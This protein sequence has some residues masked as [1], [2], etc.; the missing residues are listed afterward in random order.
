MDK[1]RVKLLEV[2]AE[3]TNRKGYLRHI[4]YYTVKTKLN[5]GSPDKV[6][7]LEKP[8][9]LKIISRIKPE[10]RKFEA[11]LSFPTSK[12]HASLIKPSSKTF[13][14]GQGSEY[15]HAVIKDVPQF[16]ENCLNPLQKRSV[17][18]MAR[19][20]LSEP[21]TPKVCLMQGPPGTG[22]S[23]TI[24]GLVLQILYSGMEGGKRNSMPRILVVAPSNA[25]VDELALKLL[26][27]RRS[28]PEN[29]KFR[30]I[31]LGI[32]KSM[33]KEVAGYSFGANVD[34]IMTKGTRR[35]KAADTL[36]QDQKAKQVAANKLFEEKID[37]E[38]A[39]NSDLASK[40]H[41]DWRDKMQQIEK[42]KEELKKP[43]DSKAERN[44]RKN[45]EDTTMADADVILSTL[46]SSLNR[47][48][49]AYFVKGVGTSRT[50]GSIRPISVCIMDEASQCVEPEALIP[51]KLGFVKL[52]MV[53][54]HEQLPATVTSMR[55][56]KFGYQ[57]SLFG[58]LF[59]FLTGG[60]GSSQL[61]KTSSAG[62][63]PPMVLGRC[64]VV[65]LETQYR[66]H[67]EIAE[68]P[69]RYFYGGLV[70]SGD[71]NRTSVVAP[72]TVIHVQGEATMEGGNCYNRMEVG[73]VM[74]VIEV[75]REMLGQKPSVGVI[76]F[77]AKQK[78]L[79]S[80]EMQ[81]KK[82]DNIVVNTVDGFQGSERDVIIIS[83]V[84]G[85]AGGIGFLQDRQRL[86][87][88]L[89]RAK[90]NLVVIGNLATLE[91]SNKMW[92]ELLK[93]AKER[94]VYYDMKKEEGRLKEILSAVNM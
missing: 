52:V 4:V 83:C 89:T 60:G 29:I 55:A 2:T 30:L 51:F 85:G 7:A 48:M 66:M 79:L 69:C 49:D 39:G 58:R 18:S 72:F 38:N 47:E 11:L 20:C 71:Q 26:A 12:L 1:E 33:K 41:R 61:D 74:K 78:Q 50:V 86:N 80:L 10:L 64:P 21:S 92:G 3:K 35:M 36:E 31:R 27:A 42:I 8:I 15:L 91:N 46:S 75:L 19:A 25:A 56:K 68:W 84:R 45:A 6:I 16:S 82:L 59:S 94:K 43:L 37:A 67:K 23:S 53:G 24:T 77:Y 34:R 54:D 28:L 73:E 70:K 5:L 93:D 22:K 17:V 14:L 87:V 88:A 44:L 32:E 76:T 90:Y 65:R 40:L 62:N 63:T 13:Q 57:Q 81:T 9:Y